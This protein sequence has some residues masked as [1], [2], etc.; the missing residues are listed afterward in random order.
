VSTLRRL[1]GR[2]LRSVMRPPAPAIARVTATGFAMPEGVDR[3]IAVHAGTTTER[4][5]PSGD[6]AAAADVVDRPG[7]WRLWAASKHRRRV[8]LMDA[9]GGLASTTY[10]Y[11]LVSNA[12]RDLRLHP[13]IDGRLVLVVNPAGGHVEVESVWVRDRRL[14]VE[15]RPHRLEPDAPSVAVLCRRGGGELVLALDTD[16][17]VL[18]LDMAEDVLASLAAGV[19]DL[20]ADVAE[21]RVP[22]AR[23]LDDI[24]DK[25]AVYRFPALDVGEARIRA[26]FTRR[27]RLAIR[28]SR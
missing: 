6:L 22:F 14:V 3:C 11:P 7:T 13:T 23:L 5:L 15:A 9:A 20:V 10:V 8:Q 26:F 2:L 4:V 17:G 27:N 16:R 1:T 19:W 18:R 21:R 25:S 12:D 24:R 28:V